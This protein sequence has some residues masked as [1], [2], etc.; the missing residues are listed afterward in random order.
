MKNRTFSGI[1]VGVAVLGWLAVGWA[2]D[3]AGSAGDRPDCPMMAGKRGEPAPTMMHGQGH[4]M[5]KGQ[6][7]GMM[8]GME[9]GDGAQA[10]QYGG[11]SGMMAGGK[12]KPG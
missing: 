12:C 11:K 3:S 4:G 5:M 10:M 2:A 9:P 7:K 6:M 8:K 1:V